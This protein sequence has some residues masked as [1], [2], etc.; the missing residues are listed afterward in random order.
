MIRLLT[1]RIRRDRV[2]LPIWILAI[3][4]VLFAASNAVKAEFGT[5]LVRSQVLKL[6]LATPA[7]LA[8]RGAPNGAGLGSFIFFQVFASL[9][10]AVGLMNTFLAARH[11]RA[12]EERGRRE[13]VAASPLPRLTPLISTLLL[14]LLANVVLAALVALAFSGAGLE[15]TGALVAGAAVGAT[16]LAFLGVGAV[17]GELAATSRGANGIAATA[18]IVAY[19]LRAAGDALGTADFDR[20][21]LA[22]A[23][24]SW[25]SPIGWG[26]RTFAFTDNDLRPLLLTMA[27]AIL[28]LGAALALNAR[29][30]LG[31]SLLPERRGP[32]RGSARLGG[33]FGLA[34]RLQWPSLIGWTVGAAAL[35]LA[36]GALATAV[37]SLTLENPALIRVLGSLGHTSRT[38]IVTV[39]V[40]AIMSLVGLLAA[41]AGIQA[42]L[43]L[44]DEESEGRAELLLSGPIRRVGWLLSSL[45]IAAWSTVVVMGATAATAWA[46]FA[47]VGDGDLGVRAIGQAMVEVPMALVFVALGALVFGVLPRLSVGLTWGLFAVGVVIGLFGALLQLPDAVLDISPVTHVPAVPFAS[48]AGEAWADIL[49]LL[50]LAIL[51]AAAASWAI[52]R[53]S[54]T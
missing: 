34:W 30:D 35:G 10:V 22:P 19:A 11:G 27:L 20:V 46:S 39:F 51:L 13:L 29:R 5:E 26:E 38:D 6:A 36:S 43:R 16:G 54:L 23:W 28:L 41:A 31:A 40:A 14:G 32:A 24:P 50:G 37:G 1:L 7:L 9:A 18:V 2:I 4:L 17:A 42:M 21:S 15:G 52:R 44:R 12:D 47:A 33:S 25:L 45:L 49:A 3:T 53:R 48:D 8:L